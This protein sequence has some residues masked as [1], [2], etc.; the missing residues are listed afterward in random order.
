M[1]VQASDDEA[2]AAP[3]PPPSHTTVDQAVEAPGVSEDLQEEPPVTEDG[4]AMDSATTAEEDPRTAASSIAVEMIP[5]NTNVP[6]LM[7]SRKCNSG[8]RH[9]KIRQKAPSIPQE[10]IL[11]RAPATPHRLRNQSPRLAKARVKAPQAPLSPTEH[12]MLWCRAAY[13]V[14]PVQYANLT[15]QQ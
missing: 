6:R 5:R 11:R 12:T 14:W 3:D 7:S 10:P 2:A 4:T 15:R 13:P 1:K 8:L 9:G